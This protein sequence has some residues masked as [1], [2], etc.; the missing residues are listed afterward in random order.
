MHTVVNSVSS[1]RHNSLNRFFFSRGYDQLTH[2]CR[3]H[4]HCRELKIRQGGTGCIT[5]SVC[6]R[7]D[8][9]LKTWFRPL[10]LSAEVKSIVV[11][12][13][14]LISSVGLLFSSL[15]C[16]TS[17]MSLVALFVL[18]L[19]IVVATCT[20]RS[21][22]SLLRALKH[23]CRHLIQMM[24]WTTVNSMMMKSSFPHCSR[25]QV[26]PITLSFGPYLDSQPPFPSRCSRR[27]RVP[28]ALQLS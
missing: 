21:P 18:A 25:P 14:P 28:L 22:C 9:S 11:H 17:V 7:T 8:G 4:C 3:C 19:T 23:P 15:C 10:V 12:S 13:F 26:V 5:F 2:E 6:S 27:I 1:A 24:S 20:A 16:G